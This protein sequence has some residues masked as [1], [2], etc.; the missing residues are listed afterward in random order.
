MR[1]SKFDYVFAGYTRTEFLI[2]W[3]AV[4]LATSKLVGLLEKRGH[5]RAL[6]CLGLGA[7][8]LGSCM[9]LLVMYSQPVTMKR[10]M[11]IDEHGNRMESRETRFT[12][13]HVEGPDKAHFATRFVSSRLGWVVQWLFYSL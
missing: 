5:V 3:D 13:N 1:S 9:D 12:C 2:A 6:V 10:A 8:G 11:L 7:G 4:S